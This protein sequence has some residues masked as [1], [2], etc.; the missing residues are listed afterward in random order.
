MLQGAVLFAVVDKI[1]ATVFPKRRGEKVYRTDLET[2]KRTQGAPTT[3][4]LGDFADDYLRKFPEALSEMLNDQPP[5]VIG[6]FIDRL[7]AAR[8]TPTAG[9]A[10][11]IA[12]G[13]DAKAMG[14][15]NGEPTQVDVFNRYS[16][17]R[18]EDERLGLAF[19]RRCV[20]VQE[21]AQQEANETGKTLSV[22][23]ERYATDRNLR[24]EKT[25]EKYG[26]PLSAVGLMS[27]NTLAL[28]VTDNPK[29]FKGLICRCGVFSPEPGGKAAI[30]KA[31]AEKA[32]AAMV[33]AG[34]AK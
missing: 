9:E 13:R 27:P 30:R 12:S 14:T 25:A 29:A 21:Y 11:A 32:M 6:A 18:D 19:A 5:E 28:V 3:S 24:D 8:R 33:A 1:I 20:Q 22:W 15:I 10:F 17:V 23:T 7:I 34:K 4:L 2:G 31:R 26:M 16:V